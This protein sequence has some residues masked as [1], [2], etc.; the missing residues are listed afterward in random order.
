MGSS[1]V[2]SSIATPGAHFSV[3]RSVL[4][5]A[6]AQLLAMPGVAAGQSPSAGNSAQ[7][8]EVI[9]TAQKRSERLQDVPVPVTALDAD[10]LAAHNQVQLQ[11][12]F[13]EVPGLNL[14]SSGN[15]QM[16]L[17]IRGL[18]AGTIAGGSPTVGVTIDDVPRG[19]NRCCADRKAHCM[20]P[21][22]SAA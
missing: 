17:S 10:T 11:D 16:S 7:L 3:L 13:A 12:Y 1:I 8:E 2:P 5:C 22:V 14:S 19:F 21:P 6:A 15:G 4:L 20:A 18:T 9:V